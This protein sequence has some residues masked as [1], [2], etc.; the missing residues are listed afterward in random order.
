MGA[1]GDAAPPRGTSGRMGLAPPHGEAWFGGAGRTPPRKVTTRSTSGGTS[2][3]GAV[4]TANSRPGQCGMVTGLPS[5]AY[6][7]G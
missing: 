3:T 6:P 5:P 4:E 2:A 1:T 7:W